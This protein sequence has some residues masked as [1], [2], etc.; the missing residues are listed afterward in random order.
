MRRCKYE[1]LA[2]LTPPKPSP[3]T[4]FSVPLN[5]LEEWTIDWTILRN[6]QALAGDPSNCHSL[7]WK[8][9][10]ESI[11]TRLGNQAHSPPEV[12]GIRQFDLSMWQQVVDYF[13]V[14]NYRGFRKFLERWSRANKRVYSL[15]YHHDEVGDSDLAYLA[16]PGAWLCDCMNTVFIVARDRRRKEM[17]L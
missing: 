6:Y 5:E 10:C 1:V 16:E 9:I 15:L 12:I 2:D 14:D 11:V 13:E 8:Y 7:N 17:S 4:N 3:A